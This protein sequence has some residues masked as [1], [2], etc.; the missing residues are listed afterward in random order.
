[1]N[2]TVKYNA[3]HNFQRI[4]REKYNAMII[5]GRDVKDLSILFNGLC[6]A[7]LESVNLDIFNVAKPGKGK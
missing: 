5:D 1:M 6:D 2:D 4:L 3:Y 7:L